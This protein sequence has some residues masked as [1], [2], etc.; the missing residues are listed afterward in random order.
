MARMLDDAPLP[1]R[2]ATPMGDDEIAVH[3]EALDDGRDPPVTLPWRPAE[4]R[5]D[6]IASHLEL[7]DLLFERLP[8]RR[9]RRRPIRH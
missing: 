8:T 6:E 9:A 3:A 5:D 7:E 2:L 4:L 1:F